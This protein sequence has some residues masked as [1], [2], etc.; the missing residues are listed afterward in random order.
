[1][2][3]FRDDLERLLNSHSAENGSNTPDFILACFLLQCLEAFD[4]AV[5]HR[6]RWY[7][8]ID[9]PGRGSVPYPEGTGGSGDAP[10]E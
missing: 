8:R 2:N 7:G 3:R 5:T 10:N 4:G 9:A 1:M 6:A